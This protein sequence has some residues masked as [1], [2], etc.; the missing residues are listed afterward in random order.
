MKVIPIYASAG[1]AGFESPAAEYVELGLSLDQLL[2]QHPQATFVG[3]ACGDSMQGVGIFDQDLLIVDRAV[4]TKKLSV[5]VAHLNGEF[6]CKVL[7][8]DKRL[9]LSAN[10]AYQSMPIS[11]LDDF[12]IE[13]VVTRSIRNHDTPFSELLTCMR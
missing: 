11:S 3:L 10:P 13:G 5:I 2:I 6:I 7:D 1:I 4:N 8:K 9:L 12:R